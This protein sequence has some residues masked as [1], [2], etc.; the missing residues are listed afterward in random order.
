M[1]FSVS[2]NKKEI[3]VQISELVGSSF[4]L[5]IRLRLTRKTHEFFRF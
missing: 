4:P 5:M 1:F 2:Y 3:N